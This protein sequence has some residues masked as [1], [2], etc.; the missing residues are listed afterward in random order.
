V[1]EHHPTAPY[2]PTGCGAVRS[3]S[4]RP[5]GCVALRPGPRPAH[6]PACLARN[7]TPWSW[8]VPE[9]AD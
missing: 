2:S 9:A 5:V 6:L 7:G 8:T 1:D 4:L 3:R